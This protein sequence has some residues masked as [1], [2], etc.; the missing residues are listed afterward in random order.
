MSPSS[1]IS[2]HSQSAEDSADK[3]VTLTKPGKRKKKGLSSQLDPLP[4]KFLLKNRVLFDHKELYY[5]NEVKVINE[6]NWDL[7]E[8][9]GKV[10]VMEY[11]MEHGLLHY[12][13]D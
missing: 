3:V 2:T 1:P 7:I 8:Q 5:K 11:C 13:I 10:E 6:A 9:A 4:A 12:L